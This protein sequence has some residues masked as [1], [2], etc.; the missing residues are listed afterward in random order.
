MHT[1][2]GRNH[3]SSLIRR[4]A[5]LT[6]FSAAST[7]TLHA[8]QSSGTAAPLPPISF[9]TS[10]AAPLNLSSSSSD[11]LS[12]T[13][14]TGATETAAAERFNLSGREDQPPPRRRY[15]RPNYHDSRTNPDGSN[16][17]TFEVG[18]GFTLPLGNTHKYLT[19]SWNIQA[20]G[21]RNFNK[22]FGLLL[23]F[24]YANF[25]LQGSNLANQQALYQAIDPV[26][27]FTGLDAHSHVW[28]FTLNPIV[29]FYTSDT[30]GAYVV[31][32]VGF[33]HKTTNFTLPGTGTYCDIYGF[34]YQYQSNYSIDKYTSN[35]PGFNGGIGFTYKFSR[36]AGERF[37]AEARYVFI[38]NSQRALSIS[39]S[40]PV[41]NAYPANS[42]RTGYIPVTFG[43][44][45]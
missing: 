28:S 39:S 45:W 30:L 19:P 42:N 6:F 34:C 36:F 22:T 18:G 5:V 25:G 23:Q 32:G 7:L 12:Y 44:R 17:Y 14:N 43:I 1:T 38:D 20:G 24:D 29:N 16:K 9:K 15:G 8:Q 40:S 2:F 3:L 10:L 31:A 13:S 11:D 37:F 27:D 21:G 35:A 26:D 4:T 41:F 33:Y